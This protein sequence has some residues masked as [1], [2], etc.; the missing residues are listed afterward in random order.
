MSTQT[1][2]SIDNAAANNKKMIEIF[3][4][5]RPHLV[6]D[7]EVSFEQVI[8]LAFPGQTPD[9]N[10]EY[11]VTYTRAQHGNASGSL[12]PGQTLRV[13]KGTS[14]GVQITTRS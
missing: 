4:N 11:I 3:V 8:A 2:P 6:A 5:A 14:F 13:K 12:A 7:K 9:A 1:D 10:T